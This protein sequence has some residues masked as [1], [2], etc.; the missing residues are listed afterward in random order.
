MKLRLLLLL[1]TAA[2][3]SHIH[4]SVA[5]AGP[6]SRDRSPELR[7][8]IGFSGFTGLKDADVDLDSLNS[9]SCATYMC[10][11]AIDIAAAYMDA[12]CNGSF[13]SYYTSYAS[14]VALYGSL[15]RRRPQ[16]DAS[17][18]PVS[19]AITLAAVAGALALVGGIM[20]GFMVRGPKVLHL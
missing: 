1:P 15:D 4:P 5:S 17:G 6:G 19:T 10:G 12:G 18:I 14:T 9:T 7:R 20:I 11:Q 13:S 16:V 2:L 3:L 8:S